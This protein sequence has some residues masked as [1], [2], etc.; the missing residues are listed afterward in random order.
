M[1]L[2]MT[3]C[4]IDALQTWS[5]TQLLCSTWTS[6]I[7]KQWALDRGANSTPA[8]HSVAFSV[9]L[10]FVS[11]HVTLT[12][13]LLTSNPITLLGY[14]NVIPYT[15]FEYF[16]IILFELHTRTHTHTHTWMNALLPRAATVVGVTNK[17]R[18]ERWNYSTIIRKVIL[19]IFV[20]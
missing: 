13:Y 5:W 18:S 1:F 20:E 17:S 11:N 2:C 7:T 9:F 3:D 4:Q 12:F 6:D 8:M 15:K 14:P 10:H 16:G 19:T